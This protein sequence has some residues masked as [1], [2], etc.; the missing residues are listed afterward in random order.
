[1]YKKFPI[2]KAGHI[3][4]SFKGDLLHIPRIVMKE[5]NIKYPCR[6][7]A[8]AINPSAVTYNDKM[9]FTPGEVVIS[10][11]RYIKVKVE[12]VSETGGEIIITKTTK[13]K[14]LVK[15]SFLIM[16]KAL[17]VSPSLKI[18]VDDSDILKHCGFGS[19]SSTIAAVASAINE[20]YGNPIQH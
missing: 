5:I 12:V 3:F 20:I 7:D 15:H 17:N 11:N 19:S 10:I 9:V 2:I 4:N 18:N 16:C 14:S 1:M 13:R 8:M 6:L